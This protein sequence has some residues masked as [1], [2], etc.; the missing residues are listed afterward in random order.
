MSI[1]KGIRGRVLF[2]AYYS[3]EGSKR[4]AFWLHVYDGMSKRLNRKE[5]TCQ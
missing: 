3:Q 4:K 1:D 2:R 5:V